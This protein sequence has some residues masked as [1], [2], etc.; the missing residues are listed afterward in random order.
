MLLT[1]SN[2]RSLVPIRGADFALI[3]SC[4]TYQVASSWTVFEDQRR[5][6]TTVLTGS[7]GPGGMIS[8]AAYARRP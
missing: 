4:V 6:P 3:P 8:A 5:A 7:D 2:A 1:C